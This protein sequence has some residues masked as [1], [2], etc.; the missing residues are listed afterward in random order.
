MHRDGQDR[1]DKI[2]PESVNVKSEASENAGVI[3]GYAI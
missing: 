1:Q 3:V 2:T